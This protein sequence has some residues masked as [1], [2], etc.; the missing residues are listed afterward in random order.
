MDDSVVTAYCFY[1]G[2]GGVVYLLNSRR[3]PAAEAKRVLTLANITKEY[4]LWP[5][6]IWPFTHLKKRRQHE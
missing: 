6:Y 3:L 5:A 1:M 4:F 2:I